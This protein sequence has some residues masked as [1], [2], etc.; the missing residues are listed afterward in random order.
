M[1]IRYLLFIF[2]IGAVVWG[3]GWLLSKKFKVKTTI[4]EKKIKVKL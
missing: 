3:V 1:I 4:K 2:F